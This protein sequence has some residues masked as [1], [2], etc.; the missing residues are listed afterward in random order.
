MVAGDMRGVAA[1]YES[2]HGLPGNTSSDDLYSYLRRVF[3]EHPWQDQRIGSLV[4][5]QGD[6]CIIGCLGVVPRPMLYNGKKITAAVSHSFLVAPELRSGMAALSLVR[7]FLAGKQD[8]SLC[9]GDDVSRRIWGV[10]G[11]STSHFYSLGWTR[12]L[13]PAHYLLSSLKRRGMRSLSASVLRPL[14]VVADMLAPRILPRLFRL[15]SPDASAEPL[16]SRR[17]VHT[18]LRATNR[19]LLSPVYGNDSFQW[20]LDT[21]A[22]N[23]NRGP[24][25]SALVQGSEGVLGWYLYNLRDAEVAEV[26]QIGAIHEQM[27]TVFEHLLWQARQDGAIVVTGQVEPALCGTL[28]SHACLLHQGS[29]NWMLLHA[30]DR[31]VTNAIHDGRAFLSRLE[32][33]WWISELLR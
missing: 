30:T 10:L 23:P 3:L 31:D 6:N 8:L 17:A 7:T 26:I 13:R 25:R 20:M 2:V 5:E 22:L 16:T 12:P 29:T 11:S 15:S 19:C 24:L 27:D 1:L 33:E 18:L 14:C 28:S 9:Q 21:L 4:V 32:A